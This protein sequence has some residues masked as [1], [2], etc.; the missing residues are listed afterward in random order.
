VFPIAS[1]GLSHALRGIFL[2]PMVL[3]QALLDWIGFASDL[4]GIIIGVL[5]LWALWANRKH[6]PAVT[7]WLRHAHLSDRVRRLRETLGKLEGL[8]YDDKD[9]RSEIVALIGQLSG[10]IK[11]LPAD[12]P[13]VQEA[14]QEI[15]AC[16]SRTVKLTEAI[17]R[18]LLHLTHVAVDN[19]VMGSDI[20]LSNNERQ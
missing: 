4:I 6:L 11:S 14:S 5:A 8:S 15:E 7:L 10:Q 9:A 16:H 12:S 18:R 20:N 13:S 1:E 17:K 19:S 3:P 2:P